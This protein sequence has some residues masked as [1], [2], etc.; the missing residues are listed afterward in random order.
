MKEKLEKIR[1][2]LKNSEKNFQKL[3]EDAKN[4][5]NL[6]VKLDVLGV[7][8]ILTLF[9]LHSLLCLIVAP[10]RNSQCPAGEMKPGETFDESKFS[11]RNSV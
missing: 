11:I 4:L 6:R 9:G 7:Y 3:L 8:S 2:N 5:T 10:N 1:K